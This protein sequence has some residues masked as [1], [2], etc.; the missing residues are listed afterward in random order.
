MD[1]RGSSSGSENK[2]VLESVGG[3]QGE[4][5]VVVVG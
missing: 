1:S 4:T 5:V 3:E 2:K